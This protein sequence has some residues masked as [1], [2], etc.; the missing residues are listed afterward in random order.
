MPAA[1]PSVCS[2]VCAVSTPG[3]FVSRSGVR[4]CQA[5][6]SVSRFSPWS[7]REDAPNVPGLLHCQNLSDA[8]PRLAY[9]LLRSLCALLPGPLPQHPPGSPRSGAPKPASRRCSKSS[10]ARAFQLTCTCP[11]GGL[12]KL[13]LQKLRHAL[14]QVQPLTISCTKRTVPVLRQHLFGAPSLRTR[15]PAGGCSGCSTCMETG[16]TFF[17]LFLFPGY[18]PLKISAWLLNLSHAMTPKPCN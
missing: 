12:A 7:S 4:Q 6:H 9:A 5:R 17:R 18:R 13:K 15:T 14:R 16:L 2:A 3:C 8:F 11:I 1:L 10:A